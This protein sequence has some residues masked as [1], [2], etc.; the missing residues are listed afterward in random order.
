MISQVPVEFGVL[1][2]MAGADDSDKQL[3]SSA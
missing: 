2:T 3:S 1:A